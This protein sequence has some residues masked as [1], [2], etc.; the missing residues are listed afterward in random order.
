MIFSP[1]SRPAF[2][3]F[4]LFALTLGIYTVTQGRIKQLMFGHDYHLWGIVEL[5]SLY[6]VPCGFNFFINQ[7]LHPG[8]KNPVRYLWI[9]TGIFALVSIA[10]AVIRPGLLMACIFPFQVFLLI[11]VLLSIIS[12]IDAVFRGNREAMVFGFGMLVLTLF[13]SYD[14]L[15]NMYILKRGYYISHW[16]LLL[17]ALTLFAILIRRIIQTY[18]E[19]GNSARKIE[20]KNIILHQAYQQME[21]L[22]KE[23]VLTQK[24]VIFRLS[25]VTEARSRETGNHVRR[26][27]EYCR[28]L[29]IGSGLPYDQVDVLKLAAPMHDI[30]KLSIP[31]AILNKPGRLTSEE[32]EIV[33]SHTVYGYEMLNK[34]ER[35]IFHAASIVAW[36]HHEKFNGGGYPRGISGED[37]HIFGRI[38]AVADV[39]DSLASD[40]CYK[41]AWEM[42]RVLSLIK[43]ER[44]KHFDPVLVDVL[45]DNLSGFMQVK[46]LFRDE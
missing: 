20:Y 41:K 45:F 43:E 35:Q 15:Q 5:V 9:L 27:A 33:K 4:G 34:S 10:A 12:V 6:C 21:D 17:F 11:N 39:F 8:R 30:G 32:F 2:A 18:R 16:G 26:V 24:E 31:D 46:E 40:R 44:G 19:A 29:A 22:Q 13:A 23:I 14:V 1:V 38:T 25:E 28:L 7:I 42:D 36:E 3:S 37:I